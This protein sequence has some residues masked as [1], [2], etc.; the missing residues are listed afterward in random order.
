[1]SEKNFNLKKYGN[2][3]CRSA[4]YCIRS[5]FSG[6]G[7]SSSGNRST[8]ESV[9]CFNVSLTDNSLDDCSDVSVSR[10]VINDDDNVKDIPGDVG[11]MSEEAVCGQEASLGL[12]KWA[13]KVT[14]PAVDPFRNYWG[15]FQAP[16][17]H[18]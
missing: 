6:V 4:S 2:A 7:S 5:C 18:R 8:P 10:D 9:S 13:E 16:V 12:E 14:N 15:L 1:M 3:I 17:N 11:D